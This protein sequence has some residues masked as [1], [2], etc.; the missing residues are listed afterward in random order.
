MKPTFFAFTW[1]CLLTVCTWAQDKNIQRY[2][3]LITPRDLKDN[4]SILASDAMDGR[5][6]GTRGQKMAASFISYHFKQLGLKA[7]VNESFYQTFYLYKNVPGEIHITTGDS[8]FQNYEDVIYFGKDDSG[9]E[10]DV[11]VIFAGRGRVEDLK[12]FDVSGKGVLIVTGQQDDYRIAVSNARAKKAKMVFILNT[13]NG[14]EFKSYSHQFREYLSDSRPSLVK[15]QV[16]ANS[17]GIFFIAPL[18]AEK[19]LNTNAEVLRKASESA[20]STSALRRIKPG[21]IKYLTTVKTDSIQTE[22][23]LGYLEG[24]DKKDELIVITAHYDHIGKDAGQTEGDHIN[25]GADD[26]GSGTVAVMQLAK[27]FAK[28]KQDGKGPRRSILF[29]TVTGEEK[30]LLGSEYYTGHPVFPLSRTVVDLNIDMIGRRDEEHTDSAPYLYVIGADKLSAELNRISESVNNKY[31]KLAFDYT[32][33]DQDHPARLYYRSDH[34]NFAQKN[35]PIIFYFDGIHEDY[36]L[37]SDEVEKIEFDLLAL[38]A[39]C[40]FYTAWEIA[41]RE[42]RIMPDA[43]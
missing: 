6:T 18:V 39:Q 34:W 33:N 31:T 23:V 32:Y 29:M 14:E 43:K 15:E 36:H 12:A 30:G 27:V 22:N 35:I 7:P 19:I 2:G 11:P 17:S 24:I 25:N 20:S 21:R 10:V 26:D 16:S 28:A 38:R 8:K 1:F 42:E 3:D 40:V 4:L 9:G 41:N 37:P 5:E 13:R